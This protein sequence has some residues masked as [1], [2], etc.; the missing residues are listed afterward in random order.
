V[1]V[2]PGYPVTEERVLRQYG[3]RRRC[4]PVPCKAL[5]KAIMAARRRLWWRRVVDWLWGA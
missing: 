4:V 3:I 2:G 1:L 5:D